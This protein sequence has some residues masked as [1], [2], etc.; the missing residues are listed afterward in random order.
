MLKA[1]FLALEKAIDDIKISKP[2]GDTLP[3]EFMLQLLEKAD[4]TP[5][6]KEIILELL[7]HVIQYLTVSSTSPYQVCVHFLQL[8]KSKK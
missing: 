3:G 6:K 4:L 1:L 2:E 8:P 7:D 5:S